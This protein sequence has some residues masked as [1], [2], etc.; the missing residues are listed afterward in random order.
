L[1]AGVVEVL[2]AMKKAT[3]RDQRL[4]WKL[5]DET[6]ERKAMAIF[7][8]VKDA[9]DNGGDYVD[10]LASIREQVERS[11]LEERND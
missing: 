5:D 4:R 3:P 1:H 10:I 2:A 6:L 8:A 9:L 7:L 11:S